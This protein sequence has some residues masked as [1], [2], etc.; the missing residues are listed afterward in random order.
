MAA[1]RSVPGALGT[2]FTFSMRVIRTLSRGCVLIAWGVLLA[3]VIRVSLSIII[4]VLW[5]L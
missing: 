3:L 2:E 4:I 5:R 1:R